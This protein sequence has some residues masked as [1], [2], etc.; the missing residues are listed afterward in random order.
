MKWDLANQL[1]TVTVGSWRPTNQTPTVTLGSWRP[2]NQI[3]TATLCGVKLG[4]LACPWCPRS[5]DLGIVGEQLIFLIWRGRW[6][7]VGV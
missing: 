7:W 4:G 5:S 1:Q 6:A 3:P 2:T